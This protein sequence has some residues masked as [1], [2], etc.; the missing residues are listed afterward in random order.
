M[1]K[2]KEGKGREIRGRERERRERKVRRTLE[3][4]REHLHRLFLGTYDISWEVLAY[5]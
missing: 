2:E 1:K 5:P 3:M 4:K